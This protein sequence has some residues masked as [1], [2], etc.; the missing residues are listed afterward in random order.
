MKNEVID[1]TTGEIK[2]AAGILNHVKTI[3]IRRKDGSL[4]EQQD[5]SACP[6]MAE[7]HTAHLSD[8][9][10]LIDKFKPDELAQYLQART[11]QK[12]EIIGHDFSQEPN[13]QEAKNITYDLRMSF[14]RLPDEVRQNF[15]N[16][17]EFLKFI[18]N[19]ANAEKMIKLGLMTKREV[20]QNQTDTL[21]NTQTQPPNQNQTTPKT[22][23]S[24]EPKS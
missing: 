24:D 16:H 5:Y 13:L 15:K 10:Y 7:Q 12:R 18:D 22:K 2:S 1:Q 8:L 11:F 14:E 9:N 19:P 6:S 23:P 3:H 20:L 17:V 4:R 21:T